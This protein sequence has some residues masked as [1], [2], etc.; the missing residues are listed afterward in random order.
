MVLLEFPSA[1]DGER[2]IEV[3]LTET[4]LRRGGILGT[5]LETYEDS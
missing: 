2:Y 5:H 4:V 1:S 3:A